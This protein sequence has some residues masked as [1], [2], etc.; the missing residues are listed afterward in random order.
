MRRATGRS[1]LDDEGR[2]LDRELSFPRFAHGHGEAVELLAAAAAAID[3]EVHH[4]IDPGAE[5]LRGNDRP[6]VTRGLEVGKREVE[7]LEIGIGLLQLR[8]SLSIESGLQ[9][10]PIEEGAGREKLLLQGRSVAR[11]LE[12]RREEQIE[13]AL[14]VQIRMLCHLEIESRNDG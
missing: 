3:R 6:P 5:E 9:R 1:L 11:G 12:V 8:E 2:D 10:V 4:E 13:P 14:E 7:E